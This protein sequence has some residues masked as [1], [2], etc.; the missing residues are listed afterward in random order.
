M[1]MDIEKAVKLLQLVKGNSLSDVENNYQKLYDHYTKSLARASTPLLRSNVQGKINNVKEAYRFIS[2]NP[3]EFDRFSKSSLQLFWAKTL[4]KVVIIGGSLIVIG[5]LTLVVSRMVLSKKFYEEGLPIYNTAIH[6]ND[7]DGLWKAID[8]FDQAIEYGN[9]DAKYYKGAAL[10]K[11]GY[12]D[13]GCTLMWEAKIDGY[14]GDLR[15]LGTFCQKK[16][17]K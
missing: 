12:R 7:K 3:K 13:E 17:D 2:E 15:V 16:I 9:V 1:A 14:K 11:L 4:G 10:H 5:L 6:Y 8:F